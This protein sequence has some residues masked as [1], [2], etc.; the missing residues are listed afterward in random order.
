M[1]VCQTPAAGSKSIHSYDPGGSVFL[2]LPLDQQPFLTG[3]L[4]Q[5]YGGKEAAT[6]SAVEAGGVM[7]MDDETG[8][9]GY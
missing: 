2:I 4:L 8:H 6:H 9:T 5:A 1:L 7:F 3:P